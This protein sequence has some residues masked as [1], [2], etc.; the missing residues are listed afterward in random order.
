MSETKKIIYI[1]TV[2]IL[3]NFQFPA[4]E[5]NYKKTIIEFVKGLSLQNPVLEEQLWKEINSC[6]TDVDQLIIGC[7]YVLASSSWGVNPKP[8]EMKMAIV[9]SIQKV[10]HELEKM[11]L[12]NHCDFEEDIKAL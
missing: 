6:F 7:I 4:E 11:N 5:E 9:N 2:D 1:L 12:L 3:E 10:Y 8:V